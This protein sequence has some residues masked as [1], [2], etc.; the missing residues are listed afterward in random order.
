MKTETIATKQESPHSDEKNSNSTDFHFS[1][2][3]YMRGNVSILWVLIIV[4]IV[5]YTYF[6]WD[7]SP[8]RAAEPDE[9]ASS[10]QKCPGMRNLIESRNWEISM[11]WL[12]DK[13]ERCL[14]IQRQ[15]SAIPQK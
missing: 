15:K 1:K 6:D 10:V 3:W 5:A 14:K 9:I 11:G 12:N 4:F 8:T 2:Y 7:I 13:T